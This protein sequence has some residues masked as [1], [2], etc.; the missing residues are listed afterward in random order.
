MIKRHF[1]AALSAKMKKFPVVT[2]LGPRQCGKTTLVQDHLKSWTYLDLERP[3][4]LAPF[5][6]DPESRLK[7]LGSQLILDEAQRCPELFPVLRSVVDA[8]RKKKGRYVLLGSASPALVRHISESLA[9]RTT[10]LDMTP[11][12][13]DEVTEQRSDLNLGSLWF[14][15]GFPEA[16]LERNNEQRSDWFEAYTRTFIERDLSA[17]GV[18]VSSVQMRKLWTMLAH[19]NGS[20]WNASHVAAALGTSYHTVNRYVDILEQTFLIRKLQPYYANLGKR[21]VK[22]PK[23]Y[24][25]DSGLL[26]YFLGVSEPKTLDVHPSRGLSWE[27]F[28]IETLISLFQI[29]HP[30]AQPMFWRTTAGAEVDL[31]MEKSGR[32]IPFEIKIHSAP[33]LRDVRGLSV[34]MKDLKIS[35]GYVIHSGSESYSLGQGIWAISAENTLKTLKAVSLL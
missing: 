22:S 35:K 14:R 25:R 15:G 16:C 7:Q 27:G 12:R 24:F 2:I 1:I 18:D 6:S 17:L 20:I 10:F 28:I 33:R 4:D 31:L 32:L 21:I 8:D 5:S 34:C 30:Q 23:V 29:V 19:L 13:W 3:S 11:F 26:H 9:G